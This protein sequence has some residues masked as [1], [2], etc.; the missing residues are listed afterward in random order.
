VCAPVDDHLRAGDD[1]KYALMF[2]FVECVNNRRVVAV[3][4]PAVIYDLLNAVV[5]GTK[6]LSYSRQT[7]VIYFDAHLKTNSFSFVINSRTPQRVGA[8]TERAGISPG[9][10]F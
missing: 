5:A 7:G 8:G 2:C 6:K 3:A 1:T 4:R 10:T 9:S